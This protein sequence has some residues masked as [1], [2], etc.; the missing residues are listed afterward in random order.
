MKTIDNEKLLKNK[1]EEIWLNYFNRYLFTHGT[2]SH[3]E[4]LLMTEKIIKFC[5]R[6]KRNG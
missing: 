6:R 3:R 4:Y 1:A 5:A 2:I